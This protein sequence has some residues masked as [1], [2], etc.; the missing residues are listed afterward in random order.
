M[1]LNDWE[2]SKMDIDI[3][4]FYSIKDELYLVDNLIYRMHQLVVPK[5][6]QRKCIKAAHSMGHFGMSKCK[7]MLR[8][9]YWFQE[10]N[11]MIEKIIGQ[12]K[13]CQITTKQ[14][15]EEPVKL[16]EIP[17]KVWS[18]IS[19]DFG[20]PYPDGSYYLVVID[21]RSRY[22][23]VEL[24]HSTALK[25]TCEKL[26]K[27]FSTHGI[28]HRLESDN[29][30]PF[31]SYGFE[32]FA[33]REGFYHHRVTPLHPRANGEAESFMK[34]L[35]KIQQISH[36]K[37]LNNSE[38]VAAVQDML[39]GYRSTPHPSTGFAPNEI[40]MNRIVRNKLD[41]NSI[42]D[43][44]RNELINENDL[45]YKLRNKKNHENRLTKETSF[46]VGDYV[47]LKQR[48]INKW[49]TAFEPTF[50]LVTMVEGSTIT[51]RRISD[52]RILKRD[53][54][55]LKLANNVVQNLEDSEKIELYDKSH[56]QDWREEL[57]AGD[58]NIGNKEEETNY[59]PDISE[60]SDLET[61][62]IQKSPMQK[63]PIP[64]VNIEPRKSGRK[65]KQ[66]AYLK[67]YE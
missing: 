16:M 60:L 11:N 66:P 47:L 42:S 53:A 5:S 21:K 8:R 6:L 55:Q 58:E 1:L 15:T 12:C 10:M 44:A 25:P 22:P 19:V 45:K 35:N 18:V 61:S 23:E 46:I 28:P 51:I 67:D 54:S 14:H 43:D 32:E 26:K 65:I 36:L 49:S 57:L 3:K 41:Y 62:P 64:K 4:P 9:K 33:K 27:M 40:L 39:V 59:N 34:L 13:E 30:P 56:E 48:K 63:S 31:N 17:Q 20:G 38:K 50:Y 2:K 24:L 52:N 29:G 7:A 37:K